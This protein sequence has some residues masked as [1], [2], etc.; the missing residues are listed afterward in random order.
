MRGLGGEP[1]FSL[2][3]QCHPL[4]WPWK[5]HNHEAEHSPLVFQVM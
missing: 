4:L 5:P 3:P 1:D 2:G